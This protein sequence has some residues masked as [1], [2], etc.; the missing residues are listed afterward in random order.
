MYDFCFSPIYAAVLALGGIAG[1]IAKGSTESLTA[2]LVSAAILAL[3]S[4]LSLKNY[5]AG[6]T[7]KPA[8]AVSLIVAAGLTYVMYARYVR[9]HKLM[10]AGI[11]AGIS[12]GM[13]GAL[14][15]VAIIS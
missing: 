8:T 2:G 9:T 7:C 15:D 6:R 11:T 5:N 10:P 4:H 1:Y 12:A 3:C 14:T 13:T